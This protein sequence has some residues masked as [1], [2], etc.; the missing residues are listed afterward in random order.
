MRPIVTVGAV[1]VML[2]GCATGPTSDESMQ[3]LVGKTIADAA[4]KAGPPVATFD[5]GDGRR[6][7]QWRTSSVASY[8]GNQTLIGNTA[9][10]SPVYSYEENCR[11]TL[12]AK[13]GNGSDLSSW[14]VVSY[15]P[16]A[17][18]C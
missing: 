3:S 15:E 4:V 7:Y 16:A 1:A 13:G 10:T 14:R 9:V 8:G 18:G 2:F 17:R 6:A 5:M 11:F 12:Y